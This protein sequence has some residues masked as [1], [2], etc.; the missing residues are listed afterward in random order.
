MSMSHTCGTVK[1]GKVREQDACIDNERKADGRQNPRV[2]DT[3]VVPFLP[4]SVPPLL[5]AFTVSR[6]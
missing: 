1:M 2:V 4:K 6:V 5:A 3:S